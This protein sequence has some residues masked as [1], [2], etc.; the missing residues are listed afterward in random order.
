M[1]IVQAG[2]PQRLVRKAAGFRRIVRYGLIV[3]SRDAQAAQVAL[4]NR[5]DTGIENLGARGARK[6][7]CRLREG[8]SR[9]SWR[10]RRTDDHRLWVHE[11]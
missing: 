1:V 4:A 2:F 10:W 6:P 5:E 8:S 7:V 9:S 11:F 3:I